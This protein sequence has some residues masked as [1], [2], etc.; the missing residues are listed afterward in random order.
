MIRRERNGGP[1]AARNTGLEHATTDLVAF[2]DSDTVAPPDWIER[3]GGHFEDPQVAAVAP[4]IGR[5]RRSPLDMGPRPHRPLRPERGADRPHRLARFDEDLRYG[6]DV[7]LIWRLLD[8]GHRVVYDPSV[9]VRTR[10]ATR[11]GGA[12]LR[13]L[14]GA[15]R[16]TRHPDPDAPRR[17]HPP[18]PATGRAELHAQGI[19][20]RLALL[21]TAELCSTRRKGVIN[22]AS[23]YGIGVL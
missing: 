17:P 11:S 22:L 6:E 4:R 20:R 16:T 8:Q 7:D 19:P 1:A 23:P 12:S 18:A 21:W 3:L 2:L 9:V 5:T 14:G 10:S 13:H 15:A